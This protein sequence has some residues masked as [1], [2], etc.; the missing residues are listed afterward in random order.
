MIC[1]ICK[2]GETAP[3]NATVTLERGKATVIFK[4]VP[5]D[6]CNNCGEHYL[7]EAVTGELLVRAEKA[8]SSGVEV[9]IQRYAA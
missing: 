4:E 7:E 5:A 8:A 2:S 9:E 6:V 3:G 1:L